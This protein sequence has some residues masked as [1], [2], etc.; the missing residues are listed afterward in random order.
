MLAPGKFVRVVDI[1]GLVYESEML[2]RD[3]SLVDGLEG[4]QA[5]V[6]AFG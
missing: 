6:Y 1:F 3:P 4:D 2:A 5:H